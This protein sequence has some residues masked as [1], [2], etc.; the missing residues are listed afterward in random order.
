MS[1]GWAYHLKTAL[2]IA[3][4]YGLLVG[5]RDALPETLKPLVVSRSAVE[6]ALGTGSTAILLGAQPSAA[7]AGV[8]PPRSSSTPP[9]LHDRDRCRDS[10]PECLRTWFNECREGMLIEAAAFRSLEDRLYRVNVD[11]DELA[12]AR[13][14]GEMLQSGNYRHLKWKCI[15]DA[16]GIPSED[17]DALFRCRAAVIQGKY[18]MIGIGRADGAQR[19]EDAA[20]YVDDAKA[21]ETHFGIASPRTELRAWAAR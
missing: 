10:E 5:N 19:R 4:G 3:L 1:G 16:A 21:C 15:G 11:R 7:A 8:A 2:W 17:T 12:A 20:A 6:R 14:Q 18:L 13:M 9:Q